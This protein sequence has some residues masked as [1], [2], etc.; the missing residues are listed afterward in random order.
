MKD[1]IKTYLDSNKRIDLYLQTE[2]GPIGLQFKN[3]K[4]IA[5]FNIRQDLYLNKKYGDN[6]NYLYLSEEVTEYLKNTDKSQFLTYESYDYYTNEEYVLIS[7]LTNIFCLTEFICPGEMASIPNS[8][9]SK[10]FIGQE[11]IKGNLAEKVKEY[12]S[13]GLEI[14]IKDKTNR[15]LFTTDDG[16]K[17]DSFDEENNYIETKEMNYEDFYNFLN[18][19]NDKFL[20][21]FYIDENMINFSIEEYEKFELGNIDFENF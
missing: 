15:L 13:K 11:L 20:S 2:N 7:E 18:T 6:L 12:I 9:L 17:V 4:L 5:Y 10:C 14:V 16:I 21:T 8:E 19:I 1:I 3:K